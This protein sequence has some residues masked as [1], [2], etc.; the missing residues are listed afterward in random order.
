MMNVLHIIAEY[1][2]ILE[3]KDYAENY[4]PKT[5]IFGAKA[6]PGYVRAKLIIKLINSVGDMINNDERINNKIKVVFIENYGVSIAEKIITA[7]DVSEQISTAG[8]EASGTGNMKFMLNGALTIGT[9]D[10]AN[11]EMR[12]QGG[13]EN[14]YIFGLV[15][16]EVDARLKY[17]GG[18]EVK[19]IYSSNRVLRHAL[20]MLIDGSIVQGNTQIFQDL[21]QTLLFG[22]YG[23]PDTYMV[24]RDFEAY[25]HT[26]ERISEDYKNRDKWVEMAINNTAMSGFFSSDRTINEYNDKIWHLKPID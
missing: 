12:E 8:K 10:G 25:M 18:D 7:A 13:E 23:Y 21:Y 4:Y 6:A 19:N 9:L 1:N 2:R 5:Y 15:T 17:A 20:E 14:I 3:D 24:I 22:D 26:Q 16:E 11:V